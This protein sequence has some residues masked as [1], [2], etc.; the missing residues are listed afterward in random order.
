MLKNNNNEKILAKR[1]IESTSHEIAR[2]KEDLLDVFLHLVILRLY[3]IK[4]KLETTFSPNTQIEQ[5]K[6]IYIKHFLHLIILRTCGIK[7]KLET[8][9]T[10][11]T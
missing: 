5:I 10:P 11:N 4:A 7:T 8:T 2:Q 1:H 3:G 6:T 9:F